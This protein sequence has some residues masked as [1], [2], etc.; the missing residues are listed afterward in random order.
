MPFSTVHPIY[1]RSGLQSQRAKVTT[2]VNPRHLVS[3]KDA[4]PASTSILSPSGDRKIYL[5]L[6][7]AAT[8]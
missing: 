7:P 1:G 4:T 8:H 5:P 6:A 2:A 3:S